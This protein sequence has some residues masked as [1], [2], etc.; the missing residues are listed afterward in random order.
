M[1]GKHWT[2]P[3]YLYC[4]ACETDVKVDVVERRDTVHNSQS[5]RNSSPNG[6]TY[7]SR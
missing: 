3:E 1:S 7:L 2:Y 6:E 5:E 4:D